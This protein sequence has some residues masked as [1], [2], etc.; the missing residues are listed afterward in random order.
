MADISEL[1]SERERTISAMQLS[2]LTHT[3]E[4]RPADRESAMALQLLED[5]ADLRQNAAV[6]QEL[7]AHMHRAFL[8]QVCSPDAYGRMISRFWPYHPDLTQVLC[9]IA[10]TSSQSLAT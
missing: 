5:A 6:E 3:A 1:Q 9:Q 8:L 7:I 10:T 2:D 4:Q